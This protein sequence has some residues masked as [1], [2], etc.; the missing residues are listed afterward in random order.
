MYSNNFVLQLDNLL[1]KQESGS[2]LWLSLAC[3]DL[4]VFG[5][6][7]RIPQK[8]AS[9]AS[10]LFGLIRQVFFAHSTSVPFDYTRMFLLIFCSSTEPTNTILICLSK[11]KS[12]NFK[13]D[14]LEFISRTRLPVRVQCTLYSGVCT[15]LTCTCR[16]S[17]EWS[18][19]T[20]LAGTSCRRVSRWSARAASGCSRRSSSSCSPSF[21]YSQTAPRF[22][23]SAS[24]S[25]SQTAHS[26]GCPPSRCVR[27][28]LSS[29]PIYCSVP[30]YKLE[31][32]WHISLVQWAVVYL[33]LKQFLRPSGGSGAG[34][35]DFY[36]RTFSKVSSSL[37][38]ENPEV[39]KFW[40]R[41]LADY[42]QFRWYLS[43]LFTVYLSVSSHMFADKMYTAVYNFQTKFPDVEWGWN[44]ALSE[45]S[46]P[47][48][49][50][51]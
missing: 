15:I 3:E 14:P 22:Q 29:Y 46:S 34:R 23:W 37:F 32:W 39:K 19:R 13:S 21:R 27:C 16:F 11:A 26:S 33:D 42:F 5:Q 41:R 30:V 17:S 36:H 51:F 20:W 12:L 48:V 10:D 18:R 44:A 49:S 8:I 4:R 2:P 24:S 47:I 7:E 45:K 1:E 28:G 35:L 25:R 40:H 50:L 6:A 43:L 9:M 31:Y 38:L